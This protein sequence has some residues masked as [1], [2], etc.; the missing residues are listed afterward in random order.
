MDF[1]K[2]IFNVLKVLVITFCSIAMFL[3]VFV[4]VVLIA[5]I[6]GKNGIEMPNEM[7]KSDKMVAIVPVIDEIGVKAKAEDFQKQLN[8]Q[9]QDKNIK[10]VVVRLDSPGGTVGDSEEMYLAIK[11]AKKRFSAKPI[12]CSLGNAAASGALYV[13]V[14][15]D[16]IVTLK[17]TITGS[18]GVIMLTPNFS[19]LMQKY[20]LEVNV[21]KSGQFKDVG[22]PFRQMTED[23]KLVLNTFVDS[24][25]NQFVTAISESRKIP[26]DEVLK[27]ADGR[28]ILG[29]DA[30]K[31]GLADYIGDVTTA[32]QVVLELLN[33][34]GSADL[35]YPKKD[36]FATLFEKLAE[37]RLGWWLWGEQS[38]VK[39]KY[40]LY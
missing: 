28:M 21:V 31:L 3:F 18:I 19:N 15:C 12:I 11:N 33:I 25:F 16:K 40:I 39:L 37:S 22:S 14:A 17:G 5:L 6:A 24:A 26:K 4:I 8:Q 27:F 7:I 35:I 10:G 23:D 13:A 1:L 36:K 38:R 9:L 20:D 34:E 2:G 32:G 29:E 30:V